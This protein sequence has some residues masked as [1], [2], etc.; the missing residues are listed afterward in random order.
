MNNNSGTILTFKDQIFLSVIT[1]LGEK[2]SPIYPKGYI[3]QNNVN[4]YILSCPD[5]CV[6]SL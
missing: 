3:F 4:I 5:N 6:N 1:C 2:Q